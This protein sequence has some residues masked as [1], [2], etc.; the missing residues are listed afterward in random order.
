MTYA[1]EKSEY[2]QRL[3]RIQASMERAGIDLLFVSDPS[4]IDYTTGY[5]VQSYGN[6]QMVIIALDEDRPYWFGRYM[7]CGG[8]RLQTKLDD[9]HI[10]SYQDTYVDAPDTHAFD[11]VADLAKSKG[12][13]RK[14]IGIEKACWYFPAKAF[15]ALQKGLPDAIFVDGSRLINWVRS[16][17]SATEVRYVRESA[18]LT[19]LGMQAG[20]DGV[21]VG[22]RQSDVAA[23]I[24]HAMVK[25][26]PEF[27]GFATET[28]LMP[29]GEMFANTY[30][31]SWS[32][33]VYLANTATG[34][35]FSGSRYKYVAPLARTVYLGK[36]PQKFLDKAQIM[37]EGLEAMVYG[38]KEGMTAEEGEAL[39]RNSAIAR[40]VDKKARIGYSAGLMYPP[41]WGEQTLSLRPGDKTVLKENMV[42]HLIPSLM[43]D[44]WG[45]EISET[46]IIGK[47]GCEALSKLP[48][49][50]VVKS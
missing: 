7:D 5:S 26:T 48:R 12:W 6:L 42:L 1:F 44:D 41:S 21:E 20:F 33:E 36:P 4:N 2:D 18:A 49:E 15:E 3:T 31:T 11:L 45:L 29:T 23:D 9:D 37:I 38:L 16:V 30:H 19:D 40:G 22:R 35:E 8:A 47:N 28:P 24:I 50:V 17:K 39:W 46:V 34:L 13:S 14:R 25:G 27:G 32:D 10:Y 43:E